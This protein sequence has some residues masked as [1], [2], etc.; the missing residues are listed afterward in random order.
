F[1]GRYRPGSRGRA[2]AGS[3]ALW[4][5]RVRAPVAAAFVEIGRVRDLEQAAPVRVD[6]VEVVV[7]VRNQE[8]ALE[9]DLPTVRR[10]DRF[11]AADRGR[12]GAG[13]T[14]AGDR[15]L[16]QPGAVRVDDPDSA[17]FGL[18]HFGRERDLVR[19]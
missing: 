15:D 17:P 5:N 2:R 1:A 7:V 10:P 16:V 6:R 13:P 11:L 3:E 14:A 8:V 12:V 19:L 4:S 18:G 9:H